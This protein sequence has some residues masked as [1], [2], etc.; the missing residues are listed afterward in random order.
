[1]P[2]AGTVAPAFAVQALALQ[3]KEGPEVWV[4]NRTPRDVSA[5]LEGLGRPMRVWQ[6]GNS[7]VEPPEP[8]A[9]ETTTRVNLGPYQVVRVEPAH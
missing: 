8:D 3:T 6:L 1:V 7:P 5:V 4:L 2:A 9:K